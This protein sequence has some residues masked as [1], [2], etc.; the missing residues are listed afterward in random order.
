[1]LL[2][3]HGHLFDHAVAKC[4]EQLRQLVNLALQ[5]KTLVGV[6]HTLASGGLL[7]HLSG[8]HDVGAVVHGLFDRSEWLMLHQ[9]G[10]CCC[11]ISACSQLCR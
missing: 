11:D 8:A 10:S 9:L 2:S 6:A 3:A 1:M 7:D 4:I 5:H